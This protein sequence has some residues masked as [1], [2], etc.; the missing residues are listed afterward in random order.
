VNPL[1]EKE[2]EKKFAVEKSQ[3]LQKRIKIRK[4]DIEKSYTL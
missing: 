1:L 4:I 3:D 2:N